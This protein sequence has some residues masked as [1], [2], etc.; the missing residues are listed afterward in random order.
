ML[1][2]LDPHTT[3]PTILPAKDEKMI[4][5]ISY[6]TTNFGRMSMAGLDPSIA[7]GF[8]CKDEND[9]DDLIEGLKKVKKKVKIMLSVI[10]GNFCQKLAGWLATIS[11]SVI[12]EVWVHVAVTW[13]N[14]AKKCPSLYSK[15]R[16]H[17]SVAVV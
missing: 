1:L 14:E 16:L 12:S 3:Q 10:G 13:K 4:P 6:H 5:D 7:L 11:S 9:L 2:F 17:A 15:P 8:F